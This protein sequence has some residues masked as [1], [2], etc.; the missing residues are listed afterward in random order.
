MYIDGGAIQLTFKGIAATSVDFGSDAA[1]HLESDAF[2]TVLEPVIQEPA[3][4][5]HF[6]DRHQ[7]HIPPPISPNLNFGSLTKFLPGAPRAN[8]TD[9]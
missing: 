1:R 6:L 4:T 9:I 8:T 7:L 2:H 5:A 3:S